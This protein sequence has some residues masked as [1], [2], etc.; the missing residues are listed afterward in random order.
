MSFL[1]AVPSPAAPPAAT[2]V[3]FVDHRGDVTFASDAARRLLALPAGRLPVALRVVAPL[4]AERLQRHP[5]ASGGECTSGG[6]TGTPRSV[7]GGERPASAAAGPCVEPR[8][9]P[10]DGGHVVLISASATGPLPCAVPS[11]GEP[12][13]VATGAPPLSFDACDFG[14]ALMALLGNLELLA[15][16]QAGDANTALGALLGDVRSSA[17]RALI[18][19]RQ[20][21]AAG[22]TAAGDGRV[23]FLP[24]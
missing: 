21:A 17:E 24:E 1:S 5:P 12:W 3:I 9:L 16:E 6:D 22:P 18:G 19:A 7:A 8:I 13:T 14:N 23:R 10:V 15:L 4:L 11:A 2:A 20:L